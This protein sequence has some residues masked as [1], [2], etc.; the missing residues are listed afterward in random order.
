[1]KE[2]TPP[3]GELRKVALPQPYAERPLPRAINDAAAA[4]VVVV[5]ATEPRLDD[6][7][8]VVMYY[9][10]GWRCQEHSRSPLFYYLPGKGP[11][12]ACYCSVQLCCSIVA[13]RQDAAAVAGR[14]MTMLTNNLMTINHQARQHRYIAAV[15]H[16]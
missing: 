4:V 7:A 6:D 9:S 3:H 15:A 11:T 12:Q 16:S 8:K 2:A 13:T 14:K 5:E 10:T 1:M